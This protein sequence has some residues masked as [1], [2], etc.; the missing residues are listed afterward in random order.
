MAQKASIEK[1][2]DAQVVQTSALD[3]SSG[4]SFDGVPSGLPAPNCSARFRSYRF[5]SMPAKDESGGYEASEIFF[6]LGGG[7][8][9]RRNLF[10]RLGIWAC[11]ETRLRVCHCWLMS[12]AIT[13]I[14]FHH[15]FEAQ[16]VAI[17]FR[18]KQEMNPHQKKQASLSLAEWNRIGWP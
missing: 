15:I 16:F 17:P 7:D 4:S 2:S 8:S 13:Y 14:L 12:R 5:D 9:M 18:P 1:A 10:R 3:P 6:F 11:C